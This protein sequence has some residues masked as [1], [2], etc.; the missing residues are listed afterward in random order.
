[1][2]LNAFSGLAIGSGGLEDVR[3]EMSREISTAR[4]KGPVIDSN[5]PQHSGGPGYWGDDSRSTGGKSPYA[6]VEGIKTVQRCVHFRYV[7][8]S[9][10][11][12]DCREGE[13]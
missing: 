3:S 10:W 7:C 6:E 1:M 4:N 11:V 8:E 9:V 12:Q 13:R 5:V 2:T